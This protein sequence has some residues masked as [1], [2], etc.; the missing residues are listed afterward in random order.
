MVETAVRMAG[1]ELQNKGLVYADDH[2]V[3]G[4]TIF[5]HQDLIS[6]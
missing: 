1:E 4:L 6:T 5:P 3:K 2:A